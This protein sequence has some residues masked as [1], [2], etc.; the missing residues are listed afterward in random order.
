MNDYVYIITFF[1]GLPFS[2][3][4]MCYLSEEQKHQHQLEIEKAKQGKFDSENEKTI[5]SKLE[6]ILIVV[7][8]FAIISLV[9][10]ALK[11]PSDFLEYVLS[12]LA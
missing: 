4:L 8:I 5:K 9:F 7:V 3:W 10:Y 6:K 12:L 2:I 11:I 1:I